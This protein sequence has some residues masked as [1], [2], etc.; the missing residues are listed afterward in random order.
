M[1]KRSW[2]FLSIVAVSINMRLP[3]TAIPPLLKPLQEA[4]GMSTGELGWLTTIPLLAFAVISPLLSKIGSKFGNERII[5][6]FIILIVLGSLFRTNFNA[7]ALM[8]GTALI[9]LGIDAGN[10]LLP[11]V[12]KKK[13]LSKPMVGMAT[14]TTSMI[15]MGAIGTG[16][17]GLIAAT[18]SLK[19]AMWC[20]VLVGIISLIGWS[21]QVL[22]NNQVIDNQQTNLKEDYKVHKS[23][24]KTKLG[25]LITIFFGLQSLLYYSLLT[26]LPAIFG[27]IGYSNLQSGT[28]VTILQIASLP[29]AFVVPLAV[30]KYK[31]A[32]VLVV[33]LGIG[34]AFGSLG[35]LFPIKNIL[36]ISMLSI[37]IGIA[38]GIAFNLAVVFFAKKST[39]AKQTADI[40]GM[41]Q[42]VGYLLAAIGPVL[43]GYLNTMTNS[44]NGVLIIS[45]TL[46]ILLFITGILV[47]KE[48]TID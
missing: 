37:M 27:S 2:L 36:W 6:L 34:F 22:S 29:W 18:F 30:E 11:A 26:W 46:S 13:M 24:W 3:I 40:S 45:I 48:K 10:V 4:T 9:G 1:N 20:L 35:I 15:T 39:D 33:I 44:W 12:I 32:N 17:A 21:P 23:V 5:F 7:L 31:N 47:E 38:T 16:A 25:W 19:I 14:Y 42:T 41:A 8:L 43:F 28:F